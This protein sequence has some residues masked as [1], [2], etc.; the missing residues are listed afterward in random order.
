VLLA[1][2]GSAAAGRAIRTFLQLDVL[3]HADHRLLV[4]GADESVA[5]QSLRDM[6]E[7][8]LARRPS[9][10]TGWIRRSL[11]RVL[12]PFAERWCADLIVLGIDPHRWPWSRWRA[13][14][15]STLIRQLNCA[16]FLQA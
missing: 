12:R 5:R 16:L 1:Y 6:A 14:E 11:S 10:E 2:D 3:R 13:P 15:T 7:Y 4:A 8:C 9:I